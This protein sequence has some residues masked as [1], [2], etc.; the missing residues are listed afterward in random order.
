[1]YKI[2]RWFSAGGKTCYTGRNDTFKLYP[3]IGVLT[4]ANIRKIDVL[5]QEDE[6]NAKHFIHSIINKLMLK[7][8]V[9]FGLYNS[10]INTETEAYKKLHKFQLLNNIQKALTE[11]KM[12]DPDDALVKNLTEKAI[13]EIEEVIAIK[14]GIP[15]QVRLTAIGCYALELSHSGNYEKA[16]YLVRS[17]LAV[18]IDYD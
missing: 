8:N 15:I 17:A 4:A 1:M 10:D 2:V 3:E 11:M 5:F 16:C 6:E 18:P 9:F 7:I 13:Q 14:E 12:R